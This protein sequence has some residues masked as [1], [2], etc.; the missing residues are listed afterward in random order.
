MLRG[1][2]PANPAQ[3]NENLRA[4]LT[5]LGFRQVASVIASGNL[6]F[7]RPDDGPHATRSTP[8]LEQ[9]IEAAW[10]ER[11][12]FTSGTFLREGPEFIQLAASGLFGE[13]EDTPGARQQVTF[14]KDPVAAADLPP[15]PEVGPA[16]VAVRDRLLAWTF[17]TTMARTPD[18]MTWLDRQFGRR[19]TT[20]TWR[21]VQ[22]IAA[23]LG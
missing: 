23:K 10:P 9:L 16:L 19:T 1:I 3:R 20:R 14:L 17:D 21:S 7:D 2:G 18:M 8:E 5:D 4:V 15:L 22:R 11:L 6:V 12:G 13:R